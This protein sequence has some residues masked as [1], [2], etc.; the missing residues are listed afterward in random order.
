[1]L[2]H[3]VAVLGDER[4]AAEGALILVDIRV[5][6][7]VRLEHRLV[8]ARIAA[9]GARVGIDVEVRQNVVHHVM[10]EAGRERTGEALE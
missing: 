1:V 4:A 6:L 8:L 9:L 2:V 3:R 10:L 7:H 5:R